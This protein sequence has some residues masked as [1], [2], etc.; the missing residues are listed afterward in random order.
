MAV[1]PIVMA[2]LQEPLLRRKSL[3]VREVDK[4]IRTLAEDLCDTMLENH[5]AGLAAPQ[6]GAHWRVCTVLGENGEVIPLINPEVVE[7]IGDV[8]QE[9][10]C[11]S[12]PDEYEEV[13]RFGHIVC[14][15]TGRDGRAQRVSVERALV[16]RKTGKSAAENL[17]TM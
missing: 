9:E 6:I 11:L 15:F 4:G 8:V 1:R 16:D 12:I 14:E 10:G 5:G 17:K 3:R 7:T 2:H 13:T